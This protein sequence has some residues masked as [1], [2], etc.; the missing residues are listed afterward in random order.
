MKMAK[1][2]SQL[3][4]LAAKKRAEEHEINRR[5][6]AHRIQNV[7]MGLNIDGSIKGA[8]PIEKSIYCKE[9]ISIHVDIPY[10][11]PSPV[12][13]SYDSMKGSTSRK[14]RQVYTGDYIVGIACMHKSNFVPVSREDDPEAYAKMRRN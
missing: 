14:D 11:R 12:V 9:L 10:R 4:K 6:K 7:K 1:S 13:S 2:K 8:K 5:T 3:K